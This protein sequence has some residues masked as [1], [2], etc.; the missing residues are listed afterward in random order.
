MFNFEIRKEPK[1]FKFWKIFPKLGT[2]KNMPTD[3]VL[4]IYKPL[5]DQAHSKLEV[6]FFFPFSK[7]RTK[8]EVW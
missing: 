1:Y 5:L 3:I 7:N 2:F 4:I 6:F 8:H